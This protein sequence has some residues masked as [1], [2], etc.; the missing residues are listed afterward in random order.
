MQIQKFPVAAKAREWEVMVI[1][2]A[3]ILKD[4]SVSSELTEYLF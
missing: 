2:I 3:N 1:L 4:E